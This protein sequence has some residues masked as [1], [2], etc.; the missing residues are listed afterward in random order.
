MWREGNTDHDV[1]R[2]LSLWECGGDGER[3][4]GLK[5]KLH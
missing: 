1:G 3:M 2:D 4:A 5:E